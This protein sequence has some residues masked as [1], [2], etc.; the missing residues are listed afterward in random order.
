[1]SRLKEEEDGFDQYDPIRIK[2]QFGAVFRRF[3]VDPQIASYQHVR[4]MVKE[5]FK[6]RKNFRL[7]YQRLVD[8]DSSES[9]DV[10]DEQ[11]LQLLS[12][13]SEKDLNNA[14]DMILKHQKEKKKNPL[15]QLIVMPPTREDSTSSSSSLPRS[16][17][18]PHLTS[19]SLGRTQE[20]PIA[21]PGTP[22]SL[23]RPLTASLS[24]LSDDW[25]VL[26]DNDL[27][28]LR[29]CQGIKNEKPAPLPARVVKKSL[30]KIKKTFRNIS[31]KQP[32][33]QS[34]WI[35]YLDNHGR[36][37]KEDDMRLKVFFG[38]VH[39]EMRC[40]IWRHL[41]GAFPSQMTARKRMQTVIDFH[42]KYARLKSEWQQNNEIDI[43]HLT[44]AVRK[45][46]LRT[47]RKQHYFDV[48]D[49]H[50]HVVKL[51]NV[52]L[53]YSFHHSDVSYAQGMS[54]LASPF[55]VLFE[56]EADSYMCFSQLMK[57]MKTVFYFDSES[58]VDKFEHLRAILAQVDLP[59][60]D[61]LAQESAEDMLFCYRWLLLDLKREF[62][63]NESLRVLEVIWSVIPSTQT[64]ITDDDDVTEVKSGSTEPVT[65]GKD[66]CAIVEELKSLNPSAYQDVIFSD[67]LEDLVEEKSDE[68]TD[69]GP[70]SQLDKADS[71]FTFKSFCFTDP[72]IADPATCGDGNPF[73][74]F[75][76]IALLSVHKQ[77]VQEKQLD[78]NELAMHYE[79]SSKRNS[80]G[81]VLSRARSLFIQYLNESEKADLY[82]LYIAIRTV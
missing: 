13:R 8:P 51:Y 60:S 32:L 78:G 68:K 6:L 56:D 55:V 43:K 74:M 42:K 7:L 38:G 19:P 53:T 31:L 61:Y 49:D 45:D 14:F 15:L 67:Q 3:P 66:M 16:L 57:R 28:S 58:M 54:D 37:V 9:D 64:D 11:E 63:F 65:E 72:R 36:L 24:P 82:P 44:D 20:I 76:C 4:A 29:A 81:K 73:A 5:A 71:S 50:P 22:S 40:I 30:N 34:D 33:T 1:M 70:V 26:T 21:F 62:P 18:S 2:V 80:A 27:P 79:R 25:L 77:H 10:A 59:Y 12:L 75:L 17:H 48:D 35:S 47:D 46:V 23:T 52:L 41:L 39:P 69:S